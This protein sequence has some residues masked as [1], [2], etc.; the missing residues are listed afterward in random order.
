MA[1]IGDLMQITEGMLCHK[2]PG[3]GS[4]EIVGVDLKILSSVKRYDVHNGL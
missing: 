1:L 4:E 2:A 3:H